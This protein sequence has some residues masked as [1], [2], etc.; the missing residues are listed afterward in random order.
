MA[1]FPCL[2]SAHAANARI[3]I[4]APRMVPQIARITPCRLTPVWVVRSARYRTRSSALDAAPGNTFD[5]EVTSEDRH[6]VPTAGVIS[7]S[8][9]RFS[10][11]VSRIR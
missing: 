8:S 9:Q 4:S 10:R 2:S 11:C 6:G 7:C 1:I 3:P 5:T